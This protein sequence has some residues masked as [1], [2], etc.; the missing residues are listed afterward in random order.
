[1]PHTTF[2]CAEG[3]GNGNCA[4]CENR[5]DFDFH[6]FGFLFFALNTRFSTNSGKPSRASR[7]IPKNA[8]STSNFGLDDES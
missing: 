5:E 8:R 6:V 3:G 4:G 1:M 7:P 2:C